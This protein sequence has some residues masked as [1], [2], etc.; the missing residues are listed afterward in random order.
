MKSTELAFGWALLGLSGCLPDD[1]KKIYSSKAVAKSRGTWCGSRGSM[2]AMTINILR[3][4]M[5]W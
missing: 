2:R 1:K 4:K 3:A 5:L